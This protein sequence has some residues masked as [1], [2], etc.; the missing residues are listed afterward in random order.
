MANQ[1]LSRLRS[2]VTTVPQW[3]CMKSALRISRS[4]LIRFPLANPTSFVL[5][6]AFAI[7]FSVAVTIAVT[8]DGTLFPDDNGYLTMADRFASGNT[9]NWDEFSTWGCGISML[10]SCC[11]LASCFVSLASTRFWARRFQYSLAPL[12]LRL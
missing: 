1:D 3:Q 6:A 5:I 12:P 11:Q 9:E 10:V 8:S 4:T 2:A 7:R